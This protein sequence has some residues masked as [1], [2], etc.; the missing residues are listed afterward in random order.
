MNGGYL[1]KGKG[2]KCNICDVEIG[3]LDT[4]HIKSKTYDGTNANHNL[5]HVCPNCHRNIHLGTIVVEG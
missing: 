3:I 5:I 1:M 2:Q 4:H